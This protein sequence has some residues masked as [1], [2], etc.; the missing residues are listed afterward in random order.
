[1]SQVPFVG[2]EGLRGAAGSPVRRLRS[3][4]VSTV[5]AIVIEGRTRVGRTKLVDTSRWTNH[6]IMRFGGRP[7]SAR[8]QHRSVL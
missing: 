5:S 7:S 4:T 6:H 8:W 2:C 3:V 1:M